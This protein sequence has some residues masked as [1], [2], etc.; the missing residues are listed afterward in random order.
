[1]IEGKQNDVNND[2]NADKDITVSDGKFFA[3]I[4]YLVFLC[5]VPLYF[6][7]DNEYALFHGRRA[8]VLFFLECAC[9]I[10][11]VIPIIGLVIGWVGFVVFGLISLFA[12][13][14][15]L[16]DERWEIPFI[17]EISRKIVL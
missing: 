3:A 2:P 13:F 11:S 9:G 1:M 6:K 10:L 15:V 7:R 4:G 14:Q 16:S 5:F 8:L 12:I 17:F